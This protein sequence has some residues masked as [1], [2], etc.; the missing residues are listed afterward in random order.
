MTKRF[1]PPEITRFKLWF[2][3]WLVAEALFVLCVTG[4]CFLEGD[5]SEWLGLLGK[6]TLAISGI[7]LVCWF[8]EGGGKE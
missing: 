6:G 5:F 2:A 3:P 4:L 7:L 1:D 8:M